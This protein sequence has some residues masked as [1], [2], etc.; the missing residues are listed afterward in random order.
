MNTENADTVDL[1]SISSRVDNQNERQLSFS[2]INVD[3]SDVLNVFDEI[4][5]N[6]VHQKCLTRSY[7][8]LLSMTLSV[9]FWIFHWLTLN[10]CENVDSENLK[11]FLCDLTTI[12]EMLAYILIGITPFLL[13][14]MIY[15]WT[16]YSCTNPMDSIRENYKFFKIENDQWKNQLNYYYKKNK[17][18]Y[19]NCF[20]RKQI[21]DL[22]DRGYGYIILS[23]HGIV[24][25]ELLL[26]S[27]KQNIIDK[28]ILL[29]EDNLIKL[30]FKRTCL[31]PWKIH[32]DIYLPEDIM[33]EQHNIQQLQQLFHIETNNN[34]LSSTYI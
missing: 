13:I 16:H 18:S 15:S 27:A 28:G 6:R 5:S 26:L 8:T 33:E 30:T 19:L 7:L 9:I 10:R 32:I 3:S 29:N 1:I 2:R 4:Y 22:Y 21:N 14:I 12:F 31:R 20:K 25:D 34:T 24:I 11:L 17:F 23:S